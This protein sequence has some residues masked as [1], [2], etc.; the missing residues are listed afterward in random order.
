MI[1]K[2][3]VDLLFKGKLSKIDFSFIDKMLENSREIRFSYPENSSASDYSEIIKILYSNDYVDFVV[4]TDVLNSDGIRIENVF[5][6]I[7]KDN[8]EVE[9][10]LFFDLFDIGYKTATDNFLILDNWAK[11]NQANYNF[12]LMICQMDNG[13]ENEYYFDSNGFG[14]LWDSVSE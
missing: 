1:N 7:G 4:T 2:L 3:L 5:I 8:E 11:K 9:V 6:N 12:E 13:N 14:P 10:L